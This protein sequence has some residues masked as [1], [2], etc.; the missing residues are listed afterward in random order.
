MGS[1]D[2]RH[3]EPKK[4]NKEKKKSTAPVIPS[5][6]NPDPDVVGKRRPRHEES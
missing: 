1:R 5:L 2:V 4:T 3:R 6:P